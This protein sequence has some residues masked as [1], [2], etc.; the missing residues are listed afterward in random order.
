MSLKEEKNCFCRRM[1]SS[2]IASDDSMGNSMKQ[3]AMINQTSEH[4]YDLVSMEHQKLAFEE[5]F[6]NTLKNNTIRCKKL[7]TIV[8]G[9]KNV[10]RPSFR[11]K[12]E[13]TSA[14]KL[15]TQHIELSTISFKLTYHINISS[16][17]LSVT[18]K[19]LYYLNDRKMNNFS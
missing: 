6:N 3:T 11:R 1:M 18:Q 4:T 13:S 12:Q 10:A 19:S 5:W 15:E 17:I 16:F 7:T 9:Q 8:S 2:S 14:E